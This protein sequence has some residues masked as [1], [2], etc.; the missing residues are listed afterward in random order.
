MSGADEWSRS[1]EQISTASAPSRRSRLS[2]G[3]QPLRLVSPLA[4]PTATPAISP[5]LASHLASPA[6][7]PRQPPIS[8]AS[9]RL[10]SPRQIFACVPFRAA[11]LTTLPP[12]PRG[13]IHLRLPPSS[14]PP[15]SS[16]PSLA[17]PPSLQASPPS[18]DSSVLTAHASPVTNVFQYQ[19]QRIL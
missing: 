13:L 18:L 1:A 14:S 11:H 3:R 4:P 16:P 15:H 6:A 12:S 10:A 17:S 9:P 2:S 19:S 8:P 5:R 7:S